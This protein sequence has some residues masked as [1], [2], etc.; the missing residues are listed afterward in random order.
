MACGGLKYALQAGLAALM[1]ALDEYVVGSEGQHALIEAANFILKQAA[2]ASPEQ[3]APRLKPLGF[4]DAHLTRL[5]A[6]L[7]GTLNSLDRPIKQ[8]ECVH[9]ATMHACTNGIH[10]I[11]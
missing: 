4:T 2:K 3:L 7:A 1:E 6:V 9:T 11:T 5:A 8:K 10:G